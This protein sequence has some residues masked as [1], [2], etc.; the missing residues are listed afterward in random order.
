MRVNLMDLEILKSED[1]ITHL[2]SQIKLLGDHNFKFV[3]VLPESYFD[4]FKLFYFT[5]KMGY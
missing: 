1:T 5:Q 3:I 2:V 4:R